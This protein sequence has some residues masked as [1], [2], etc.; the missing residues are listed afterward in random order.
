MKLRNRIFG[1]FGLKTNKAE[2]TGTA[3]YYPSG[4]KAGY[5][6][7]M[8]RNRDEIVMGE[9]D[10]RLYFRT[11]V[12]IDREESFIHLTTIVKFHNV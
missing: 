9:D 1:I 11:S 12:L 3:A 7:V 4:S 10:R 5:F 6:T 2:D 8:E